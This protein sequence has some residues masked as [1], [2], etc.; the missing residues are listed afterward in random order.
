MAGLTAK[1]EY[2]L[3]LYGCEERAVFKYFL[4][5][6]VLRQFINFILNIK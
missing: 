2:G 5:V 4:H 6:V 1:L 3:S